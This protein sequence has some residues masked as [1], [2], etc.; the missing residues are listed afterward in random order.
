VYSGGRIFTRPGA[1]LAARVE[2]GGNVTYWGDAVVESSVRHG[3]VVAEGSAADADRR[4]AELLGPVFRAP[5]PPAA[6]VPPIPAVPAAS[7]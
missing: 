1:T 6:P 5:V 7:Y 3:G 4:L 2:Q